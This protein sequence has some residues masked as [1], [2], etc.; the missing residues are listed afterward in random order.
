VSAREGVAVRR[1]R[2][3]DWPAV[4]GLLREIDEQHAALAPGYF[5]LATRAETEWR[6]LLGDATAAALVA[7]EAEAPNVARGFLSL[8]VF[9]TPADP[10]MVPRRRG[11]LET[12]VVATARRR[13]GIGR[14]LLAEGTAWARGQGAVEMVLTAWVGNA[15]ADAFYER[16]G[17][18]LLS[19]VLHA[20]L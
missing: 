17:Y 13:L 9:D 16:L 10:A 7:V 3:E 19:R 15:E 4:E 18:R 12:L 1:A 8:R 5:R 6:R 20:Q 2:Q 14:R 11:H